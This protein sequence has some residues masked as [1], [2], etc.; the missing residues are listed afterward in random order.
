M[1]P[2]RLTKKK[3]AKSGKYYRDNPDKE[4]EKNEYDRAYYRRNKKKLNKSRA[5]RKKY[6]DRAERKGVNTEGKDVAHTSKGLKLK[7]IRKNRGSKGDSAG[8]RRARG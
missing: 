5:E 7:S 8:D 2:K 4:D 1:P 6:R 3:L